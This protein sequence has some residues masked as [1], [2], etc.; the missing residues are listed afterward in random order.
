MLLFTNM[1]HV[2]LELPYYFYD[3][4]LNNEHT[5]DE[6]CNHSIELGNEVFANTIPEANQVST[7]SYGGYTDGG[8]MVKAD[9]YD[10]KSLRIDNNNIQ[11]QGLES[12]INF[13][14]KA[15]RGYFERGNG[16]S[17][18]TMETANYTTSGKDGREL[19]QMY[20][21][22]KHGVRPARFLTS[23]DGVTYSGLQYNNYYISPESIVGYDPNAYKSTN[24]I[25]SVNNEY[26]KQLLLATN[27][28]NNWD[29]EKIKETINK[30]WN[31]YVKKNTV[32]SIQYR[33]EFASLF[34]SSGANINSVTSLPYLENYIN[35]IL[36]KNS[37]P[38][39]ASFSITSKTQEFYIRQLFMASM[40]L[41]LANPS[42]GVS[43]T[44]GNSAGSMYKGDKILNNLN[45]WIDGQGNHKDNDFHFAIK[46]EVYIS[47]VAKDKSN[48]LFDRWDYAY[49]AATENSFREK[50]A[51]V[52]GLNLGYSNPMYYSFGGI[53]YTDS[54]K[55]V[56]N[57][58]FLE[59][60]K[61]AHSNVGM[62][63]KRRNNSLA[64]DRFLML[65]KWQIDS[66]GTIKNLVVN[67]VEKP[68]WNY[69]GILEFKTPGYLKNNPNVTMN[70][71]FGYIGV[72]GEMDGESL[73]PNPKINSEAF[74]ET[75]LVEKDKKG[76]A[77]SYIDFV[78]PDKRSSD[79][80]SNYKLKIGVDEW[81]SQDEELN[82]LRKLIERCRDTSQ[83][84]S[85]SENSRLPVE[86]KVVRSIVNGGQAGKI[87]DDAMLSSTVLHTCGQ[88]N[89]TIEDSGNGTA[90]VRFNIVPSSG[91]CPN[92]ILNRIESPIKKAQGKTGVDAFTEIN[93]CVIDSLFSKDRWSRIKFKDTDIEIT[94][95]EGGTTVVNYDYSYTIKTPTFKENIPAYGD[96][97]KDL[98][99]KSNNYIG[100]GYEV[101]PEGGVVYPNSDWINSGDGKYIT[102]STIRRSVTFRRTSE[103]PSYTNF[104]HE[105]KNDFY[106]EIKQ[107]SP[108]NE[109]FEAMSGV[110]TTRDLY[111]SVSGTDFRVDFNA[112]NEARL[113]P[114]S[115][116][117]Y[118]Y[119]V[120]VNSC[121]G[122]PSPKE[123]AGPCGSCGNPC[124]GHP[125]PEGSTITHSSHIQHTIQHPQNHTWTYNI[126]IPIEAFTY[127]DMKDT[128]VWRLA[129][130]GLKGGEEFLQIPNPTYQMGTQGWVYNQQNYSS[131]NGR[132][133][134]S[135][136][137]NSNAQSNNAKFG[138]NSRVFNVSGSSGES[139]ALTEALSLVNNAK[140]SE[141]SFKATIVSDYVVLKTSEGYQVPY[142][143][144]QE[145]DTQAKPSTAPNFTSK[146]GTSTTTDI[147][148]VNKQLTIDD[149]WNRNSNKLTAATK[150]NGWSTQSIT[151]AGYNSDY[152][153]INDKYVNNVH[154]DFINSSN[155]LEQALIKYG[156]TLS[157][158]YPNQKKDGTGTTTF[159]KDKANKD[160]IKTGLSFIDGHSSNKINNNRPS[161]GEYNT[162]TTWLKYNRISMY[163]NNSDKGEKT[164]Y[165]GK[166]DINGAGTWTKNNIPYFAGADKV[167]NIVVHDPVSTEYSVV[168]TNPS[169]LDKRTNAKLMQGGDPIGLQGG[170]CPLFGCQFSTLECNEP[171]VPHTASCYSLVVD[172]IQHI[173]GNNSHEHTS[174]CYHVHTEA[175]YPVVNNECT[176]SHCG[177]VNCSN[178]CGNH[179]YNC[180]YDCPVNN[181]LGGVN[182]SQT[183]TGRINYEST[184][185][186]TD[187]LIFTALG[188]GSVE[189]YSTD[190]GDD[191]RGR[192]YINNDLIENNDDGGSHL[193]FNCGT[194]NF[195]KDDIIR[196]NV[197]NY[198]STSSSWADVVAVINQTIL[199]ICGKGEMDC[200][201]IPNKHVCTS[202]CKTSYKQ[203]L[204]CS[205]PHHYKPGEPTDINNPKY[206]YDLGDPRCWKRCGN[207]QNHG[208]KISIPLEDS[209][210]TAELGG[211]FINLDREFKIYYP[212]IGDFAQNPSLQGISETTKTRG[213]GY[214]NEMDTFEWTAHRWVR[215]PVNVIDPKGNMRLAWEQ[216]D[217]NE[218]ST[219]NTEFTF[220]C[221]LN[222]NEM[223]KSEVKFTSTADNLNDAVGI[224]DDYYDESDNE[225]NKNRPDNIYKAKH[226][227]HK[228][229]YID[230]VGSLGSLTLHDTGD[231]RFANFFKENKGDGT[232]IIPN[233]V[234]NVYLHKPNNIV[235]DTVNSR[236]DNITKSIKW[237]DTYG[238][239][240][241]DIGGKS[242]GLNN[243]KTPYKL[244]LVPKYNNISE[245]RKQLMRPGYNL[246]MDAETIGNYYGENLD[247]TAEQFI[248]S[249]LQNK[250]Q[251]EP[252]YYSLDL[253]TGIYT[254]V[255][256][257][258]G[259]NN[260]FMLVNDYISGDNSVPLQNHYLY[261]D[262]LNE[263]DRRNTTIKEK[264]ATTSVVNYRTEQVYNTKSKV[265]QPNTSKD[266]IG[267]ADIL[268]LSDVNRTFIGSSKTYGVNKNP[269]SLLNEVGYQEQSQRWNF[270]VNVP[271]SSVFVEAGKECNEINIKT[272]QSENRVIVGTLDLKVRGSVWTLQYDGSKMNNLGFQ[273]FD[274]GK[275]YTTPKFD[276]KGK[277]TTDPNKDV[278]SRNP[279]VVVYSSTKTSKD[280]IESGG[281]H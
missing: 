106:S 3:N 66:A 153:N 113:N 243:L 260:D 10:T 279:I 121:T 96:S 16:I 267:S 130:W 162:G 110:P 209:G 268:Y 9:F 167:N 115:Y 31:D 157:Q 231:F 109:T 230:V 18:L 233:L 240:H 94:S 14:S 241:S 119:I 147:L 107:G 78:F 261:L 114:N 188:N 133:I 206:H 83:I 140:N 169:E 159:G 205:N 57:K 272:L 75:A 219:T 134:F 68:S 177:N 118:T 221:V 13:N 91:N 229:V 108:T 190:Y 127:F 15:E 168:L 103:T 27:N 264:E 89:L 246:Y 196:L 37:T 112:S 25:L 281:T 255:D 99:R 138:D 160:H 76:D 44:D 131:M 155:P 179:R 198:G 70:T 45:K 34:G 50:I 111:I 38:P 237:L 248:D 166:F 80:I 92:S 175:C 217:L 156:L 273:I 150:S 23:Q 48:A 117:T 124:P 26:M 54:N 71:G 136:A 266:I 56:L 5:H 55:D 161:N 191:P 64:Y 88:H 164:V 35:N 262:W 270:T 81:Y 32:Q 17:G 170:F 6:D 30:L 101:V 116:R 67:G 216:I 104:E 22:G 173:G 259:I 211:V 238:N 253:N 187:F 98:M 12:Y 174:E 181:Y 158:T 97:T 178:Y 263:S 102:S 197:Y 165:K 84:A 245:L 141:A 29:K 65:S 137:M 215:F 239:M 204:T 33:K 126:H 249:S 193:N 39:G 82:G 60:I 218:F 234:P 36:V 232:D 228:S 135:Q 151:Y 212:F 276:D 125:G 189:F 183:K 201:N 47:R 58:Q 148:K 278:T 21:F 176:C 269:G 171:L 277:P 224:T 51:I 184:S 252:Q 145:T 62:G 7:G 220:Y 132:L 213:K 244:P 200:T 123:C 41:V 172:D 242:G 163:V 85:G 185:K 42:D 95:V 210:G 214:S 146:G 251:I 20:A 194:I 90:I 258:Y 28:G 4:L 195:K 142:F 257:Y 24:G 1:P 100:K 11:K 8:I 93:N 154:K 223:A 182:G 52:P 256:V 49:W 63:V 275:S 202:Q 19:A 271:S 235:S 59:Q 225:T 247:D 250:M 274:S 120:N 236:L 186:G 207:D 129:E 73:K 143:F 122:D 139:T 227:A 128:E 222:N 280:D 72:T 203:T 53:E 208:T 152:S 40:A 265:R 69:K 192:V 87:F 254:P 149:F 199:P 144:T 2:H 43:F 46:L 77:T 86:L 79:T 74:T 61:Q 105:K 226:T 180:S